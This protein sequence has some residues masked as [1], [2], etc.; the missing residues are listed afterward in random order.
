MHSHSSACAHRPRARGSVTACPAWCRGCTASRIAAHRRSVAAPLR[1]VPPM[2]PACAPSAP[3][4]P[5]PLRTSAYPPCAAC[6]SAPA[7]SARAV[8]QVQ[9]LYCN[10]ALPISLTLSQYNW[11]VAQIHYALF[12]FSFLPAT[13]KYK[14]YIP[15]FFPE[16]S[17]KFI[18]NY[19]IQFSSILQLV[20]P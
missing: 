14:N 10:T 18:K 11:A 1:P 17:N 4:Y 20:K 13:G 8:S 16:Y 12:F 5:A 9:W 2:P 3:A 19:F 7:P 15:I 6:L